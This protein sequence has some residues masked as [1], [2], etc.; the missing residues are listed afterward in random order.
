[1]SRL[2][3]WIKN[4]KLSVQIYKYLNEPGKITDARYYYKKYLKMKHSDSELNSF[5]N[6]RLK[7]LKKK[8][9]KKNISNQLLKAIDAILKEIK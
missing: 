2:T 8:K 5:A 4:H 1:M 7:A 9:G 3:K 6:K